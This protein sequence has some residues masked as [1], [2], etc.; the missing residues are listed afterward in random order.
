MMSMIKRFVKSQSAVLKI[1]VCDPHSNNSCARHFTRM[2][3]VGPIVLGAACGVANYHLVQRFWRRPQYTLVH[4]DE[5]ECTV[6]RNWKWC[7]DGETKI[8]VDDILHYTVRFTPPARRR[9]ITAL[10]SSSSSAAEKEQ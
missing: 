1:V 10:P 3:R 7:P 6:K 9:T 8:D 2:Q 5:A 4:A